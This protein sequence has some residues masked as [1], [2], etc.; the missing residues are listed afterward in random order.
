MF[1]PRRTKQQVIN[2]LVRLAGGER[3]LEAAMEHVTGGRGGRVD[4]TKLIEHLMLRR[5]VAREIAR[6]M[7]AAGG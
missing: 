4:T 2:D 5:K 1:K 6:E 7:A 3:E